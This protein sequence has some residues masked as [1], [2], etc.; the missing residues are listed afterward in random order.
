MEGEGRSYADWGV[1]KREGRLAFQAK[2]RDY[3][4]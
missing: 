3:V 4:C 1:G 2:A